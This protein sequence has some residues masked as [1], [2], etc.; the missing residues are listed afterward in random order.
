MPVSE[1]SLEV[2]TETAKISIITG[3]CRSGHTSVEFGLLQI[4]QKH[5]R[6]VVKLSDY[7]DFTVM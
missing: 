2:T 1:I 6:R 5:T 7:R 3:G 4:S